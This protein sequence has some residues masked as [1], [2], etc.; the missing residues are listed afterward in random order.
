ME[1]VGKF[2]PTTWSVWDQVLTMASFG[3]F[4]GLVAYGIFDGSIRVSLAPGTD[5]ADW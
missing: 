3:V 1:N 2:S 5:K 4:S